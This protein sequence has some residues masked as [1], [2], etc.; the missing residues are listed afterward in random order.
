MLEIVKTLPKFALTVSLI[1]VVITA[2]YL[3]GFGAGVEWHPHPTA[4]TASASPLDGPY[5]NVD[6]PTSSDGQS[7][8]DKFQIFWEVW[9]LIESDFYGPIPDDQE[10]VYS[11]IRGMI[12][13]LGDEHTTF[14]TPQQRAIV[15][16]DDSG[17]FEGIGASIRFDEE[18][19]HPRITQI[20]AGQ[21]AARAGLLPGDLILAVDDATAK[22][23]TVL[24]TISLIRGP[25]GST[26]HLTIQRETE[27]N[28]DSFVVPIVR[29]KIDIP[30]IETEI[31][32]GNVAYLRLTDFNTV[33]TERLQEAL[34]G[35]LAHDPRGLVFDLRGNPGGFLHVAVEIGSE[36]VPA[37]NIVTE[38][39]KDG[40]EAVFEAHP[41]GLLTD[42]T[43]P[44]VVLVDQGTASAAEIVAAAIQDSDRGI[45]LGDQTFGKSSVQIPHGLSDGSEL[46]V[47]IASW[48]T[49]DGITIEEGLTPDIKE[50]MTPEDI[51]AGQDPQKKRAVEYILANSQPGETR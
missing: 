47:T 38:K 1:A 41:G 45:L 16:S 22:D 5:V 21:P 46:R 9:N 37:G 17:S 31:L 18:T 24:E 44:L 2:A 11:A 51:E 36:F 29:E 35:L 25:E 3:A 7:L 6:V 15:A 28:L 32:E 39:T 34:K 8:D 33:A 20:F 30:I 42:S 26:V 19:D 43:L 12:S 13:S 14:L 48:F 27:G 40:T 50:E 10:R 4:H 23:M 49:P